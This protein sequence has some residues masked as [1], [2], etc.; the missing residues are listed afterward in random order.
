MIKRLLSLSVL[1]FIAF[2]IQ[3]QVYS[4]NFGSMGDSI[5]SGSASSPTFLPTPPDGAVAYARVGTGGGK[6]VARTHSGFGT[7]SSLRIQAPTSSSVNKFSIHSIVNPTTTLGIKVTFSIGDSANTPASNI[8]SGT[9]YFFAGNGSNFANASQF[10]GTQTF[11]GIR[12]VLG[13][14]NAALSV[15]LPSAAW[16]SDPSAPITVPYGSPVT[17][18]LYMNNGS[19]SVNYTDINNTVR[20]L[21]AGYTDLFANG[22][23][24]TSVPSPGIAATTVLDDMMF[25]A[26]TST[27]NQANLFIDDIVYTN[28]IVNNTLP[29]KLT[30]F[31]AIPD[32]SSVRLL[33]KTEAESDITDY[34][35]EQSVNGTTFSQVGKVAAMKVNGSSYSFTHTSPASK[36]FYRLKFVKDDGTSE[37]SHIITARLPSGTS[38]LKAWFSEDAIHVTRHSNAIIKVFDLNGN[39]VFSQEIQHSDYAVDIA[40]LAPGNYVAVVESDDRTTVL[41]FVK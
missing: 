36:N 24:Q 21:A 25:Y 10:S 29:L 11:A 5:T 28:N 32:N 35:V 15:R 17:V 19:T 7:G 27:G 16:Y 38:D 6:V 14:S 33:W 23:Y 1:L 41:K 37:Y 8:S 26:E 39:R 9:F 13:A 18:A 31:D 20:T 2:N 30:F 12:L 22:V 3:A 4:Y 40:F 34:I